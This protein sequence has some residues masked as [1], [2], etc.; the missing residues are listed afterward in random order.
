MNIPNLPDSA[1]EISEVVQVKELKNELL[2]QLQN[3]LKE[4]SHFT[5]Q[6][7]LSLKGI[8][9][10]LETLLSLEFFK[11]ADAIDASLRNSVEW[12]MHAS[13]GLKSKMKEYEGFF[14]AFNASIQKNE[15][16]IT[17]ILHQNTEKITSQILALENQIK[18]SAHK[19]SADYQAF[20]EQEKQNASEQ[21]NKNKQES[22]ETLKQEKESANEAI[23]KN[24][25]ESLLALKQ[26]KES[27]NEAIEKNK[28]ESLTSI[29]EAKESA[30]AAIE[31]NRQE[32]LL[33]LKQEKESAN[34]EIQEAKQ[35]A[36]NELKKELEPKVS[37]LFVGAYTI[38]EMINIAGGQ[39][40]IKDLSDHALEKSKKY[41][42]EVFLFFSNSN[43]SKKEALFRLQ[44]SEGVLKESVQKFTL[45]YQ[46]KGTYHTKLLGENASGVLSLHHVDFNGNI[47]KITTIIQEIPNHAIV[48]KELEND[49][50][51]DASIFQ[52]Q[53]HIGRKI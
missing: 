51:K 21:I 40:K 13:E 16:E 23:E 11:N 53:F 45:K 24:R 30:N 34:K 25:Q 47:N 43:Y 19:L 6:V 44:T 12:L 9:R 17:E 37:G 35:T 10:I 1:L 28:S 32:S 14:S 7:R 29:N 27:A 20:L 15:Q 31:K 49:R 48:N 5:D 4:N 33:A 38:E 39:G 36:F 50:F 18:K 41:L 8:A 22:L 2:E 46:E 52:Q 26:E 42:I 3:A